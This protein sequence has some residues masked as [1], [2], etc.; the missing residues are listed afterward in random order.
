MI[1]NRQVV[2]LLHPAHGEYVHFFFN[3]A[4]NNKNYILTLDSKY[5]AFCRI[6]FH[7][8]TP[9]HISEQR[10]RFGAIVK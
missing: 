3:L 4:I 8:S 10:S 1:S 5:K 9:R 7:I 6:Y 2:H